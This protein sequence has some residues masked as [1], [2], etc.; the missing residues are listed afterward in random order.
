MT[1]GKKV[2]D[3]GEYMFTRAAYDEL[4]TAQ[5]AYD[6]H[7][8]ISLALTEQKGVWSMV[9]VALGGDTWPEIAHRSMW[10]GSWPNSTAVSFGSFLFAG[11]HRCVRMVESAHEARELPSRPK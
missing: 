10:S 11:C 5:L 7:F 1:T 8:D 6:V 9:I 3:A 2:G 4:A